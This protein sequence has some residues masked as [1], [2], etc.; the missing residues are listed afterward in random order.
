MV[1]PTLGADTAGLF[2]IAAAQ[3]Y[4]LWAIGTFGM[5]TFQASDA[6][7][8]FSFGTYVRSRFVTV[9]AMM[10]V[11]AGFLLFEG[12]VGAYSLAKIGVIGVM[13]GLRALD[14]LEDVVIGGFQQSDRL[15]I[16]AKLSTIRVGL[17]SAIILVCVVVTRQLVW[18][19]AAGFVVSIV[20]LGLLVRS[21]VPGRLSPMRDGGGL[22]PVG[23]LLWLCS[24]MFL[25]SFL[26][27][28]IANAPKYAIEAVLD[29]G[30]QGYF[31]LLSAPTF[32]VS[33]I[34]GMIY[35]PLVVRLSRY[36]VTGQTR[37]FNRL[38]IRVL[39][40]IGIVTGIGLI[41]GFFL[42]IPILQ[43]FAQGSLAGMRR[44]LMLL[45]LA[46]G[47]LAVAAFFAAL[48]VIIRHQVRYSIALAVTA[49][50]G[51]TGV[52][53]VRQWGMSGAVLLYLALFVLETVLLAVFTLRSLRHGQNLPEETV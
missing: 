3:A 46:S 10:V 41:G 37:L 29:S 14:S 6:R 38:V 36:H 1:F 8:S 44:D 13:I 49:L 33:L 45:L 12:L 48:L 25:A 21:S 22:R 50:V 7:Y 15:D 5:R 27:M 23:R 24:P 31:N 40:I 26:T 39:A 35:G 34:S 18:S 53:W 16:G 2:S 9:G 52:F 51:L 4:L 19:L 11:G 20:V 47:F 17:T 43:L 28:W 42:G 32:L 30:A